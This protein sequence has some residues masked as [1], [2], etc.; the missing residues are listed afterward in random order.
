MEQLLYYFY[1]Y[2]A[3]LHK[4]HQIV[5]QVTNQKKQTGISI[6]AIYFC[7]KATSLVIFYFRS[8]PLQWWVLPYPKVS[9]AHVYWFRNLRGIG[10]CHIKQ[11]RVP[12]FNLLKK[13][14]KSF[15]WDYDL[16]LTQNKYPL[17]CVCLSF[18]LF[19]FLLPLSSIYI[20]VVFVV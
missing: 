4:V 7:S 3:L 11:C 18:P 10:L 5:P 8:C 20:F 2:G 19:C 15:R 6:I 16:V 1:H 14:L 9:T 17:S 12:C 13:T